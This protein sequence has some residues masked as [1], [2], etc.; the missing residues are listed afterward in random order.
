MVFLGIDGGGTKTE[1]VLFDE[2]GE[3][4][5]RSLQDSACH[6]QSGSDKLS[7]VLEDGVND[8][9][10]QANKKFED[11]TA[12]GFGVAGL[13]EDK[14]KDKASIDI[15][16][17]FFKDIPLVI[18]NDV[19]VAYIGAFGYE[20]GINIVAGTGSMGFGMDD[21]GNVARCGGWGHEIGD[22]GSGYWLGKKA[23]E[24]FTKQADN[25]M[26]KSYLYEMVKEKL[27]LED[28]F[29]IMTIFQDEYF[30]SRTKTASLQHILLDAAKAGDI[31]AI[32]AYEGAAKE[33]IMLGV[34][35]RD[36]LDF[37]EPPLKLSY[38]G[39]IFNVDEFLLS[40]FKNRAEDMGFTIC[41][42]MFTPIEGAV[43]MAAGQVG[44]QELIKRNLSSKK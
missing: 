33:L 8:V 44:K 16:K 15:C 20:P 38:T 41:E 10:M 11:I 30:M 40:P 3:M 5:S 9:L 7:R 21:K 6:W 13:G 2:N 32:Q 18:E 26:K 17:N 12:V 39:G 31:S 43:I 25:R 4:L 24:I 1:F 19:H 42:P 22:E 34:A 23:V 37:K 29:E 35:I 36:S 27:N 28:D 14:D